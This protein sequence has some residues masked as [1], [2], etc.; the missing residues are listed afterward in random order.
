[1]A[2][3]KSSSQPNWFYRILCLGKWEM[4]EEEDFQPADGSAPQTVRSYIFF[5][6]PMFVLF[7]AL[8]LIFAGAAVTIRI[9]QHVFSQ[10]SLLWTIGWLI[11]SVGFCGF[12]LWMFKYRFALIPGGNLAYRQLWGPTMYFMDCR[13][14]WWEGLTTT[15]YVPGDQE[16]SVSTA[17]STDD[18]N[19]LTSYV[20]FGGTATQSSEVLFETQANFRLNVRRYP[21]R[22]DRKSVV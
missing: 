13:I 22:I 14:F 21:Y 17:K 9:G 5:R 18:E 16:I 2:T 1:M 19:A 11:V 4:V 7:V 8:P 10:A 15:V 6:D 3:V 20:L 12:A